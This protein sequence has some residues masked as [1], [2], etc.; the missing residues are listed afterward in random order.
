MDND[1]L[2]LRLEDT[3]PYPGDTMF[4]I[5]GLSAEEYLD[6]IYGNWRELP[7]KEKRFSHT[8]EFVE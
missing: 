4:K 3:V 5:D 7:P 1:R 8:V 6:N 2:L